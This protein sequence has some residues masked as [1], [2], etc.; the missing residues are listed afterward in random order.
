MGNHRLPNAI[1][2]A[3]L[4]FLLPAGLR[5]ARAG[6][7]TNTSGSSTFTDCTAVTQIPPAECSAL[8]ALYNGTNGPGWTNRNNWL[9]TDTPGDWK[10]V[11]V[12]GGHVTLI[13]LRN[14]NLAGSIPSTLTSLASLTYLDL[15]SNQLSGSIPA[16]LASLASLQIL[17]LH[18]NQLSGSIPPELGG[19][20]SLTDLELGN[21]QLS[22]SIPPELGNLTGLQNL[23]LYYNHLSGSIP[24]ELGNLTGLQ[25]LD[26]YYNQLSGGLPPEL[27]NLTNLHSLDLADNQLI[28]SIPLSFTSLTHLSFFYATY[29]GLCEPQDSGFQTWKATVT[30][31]ASRG[32]C[33]SISGTVRVG[34][35]P[36]AGV[37]IS[38]TSG[39]S[40]IYGQTTASQADGSYTLSNLP[41][42]GYNLTPSLAG[43]KFMPDSIFTNAN[44]TGVDFSAIQIFFFFIPMVT[45]S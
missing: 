17:A 45:K 1:L 22:G 27:G 20:A 35:R 6:A 3:V 28:G 19:L 23:E 9:V 15:D 42:G 25:N 10:G 16:S 34:A 37:T 18:L 5:Q 33:Y 4:L 32:L 29:T 24:P 7:P 38:L 44:V 40:N 12:S 13:A 21:N 31:W 36:L 30:T 41:P 11:T 43:Y 39:I 2:L 26:V 14:N 8:V